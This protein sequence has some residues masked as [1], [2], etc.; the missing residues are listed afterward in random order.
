MT[1]LNGTGPV[2]IVDDDEIDLELLATFYARSDLQ[3]RFELET[4]RDGASFLTRM[5]QVE[6]EGAM[7]PSIVLLDI[8]MPRMD[9]F[10][11]LARLRASPSF[12]ELP[13]VMFLSNS[14]SPRDM[15]RCA[16]LGAAFQEKFDRGADCVAFFNS[17]DGAERSA[18]VATAEATVE[19]GV[20][21][22]SGSVEL[23]RP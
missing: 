15:Q 17:L 16:E 22:S 9:G 6:R 3:G 20:A 1:T 21:A 14:D 13:A 11:V 7:M 5:E 10:E 8:N 18:D 23:G 4:Y 2:V 12:V 19:D